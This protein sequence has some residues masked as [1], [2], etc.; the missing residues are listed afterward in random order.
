MRKEK[1]E[2]RLSSEE[3]DALLLKAAKYSLSGEKCTSQ[4]R[5]KLQTWSPGI[6]EDQLSAIIEKLCTERYIDEE[7][8]AAA[9]V[10]D[11]HRFNKWGAVRIAM[12]LKSRGIDKS[13]IDN[14]LSEIS[15]GEWLET[16]VTLLQQRSRVLSAKSPY[17]LRSKLYRWLYAKGYPSDIVSKALEKLDL[18]DDEEGDW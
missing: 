17:E 12:E 6:A 8:Y 13:I 10:S 5:E 18:S 3:Y 15:S 14:A 16:A 7:R 2:V 4:L 1:E 11:K 9:F